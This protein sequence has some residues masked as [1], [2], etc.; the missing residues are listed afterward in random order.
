MCERA[1]TEENSAVPRSVSKLRESSSDEVNE[2]DEGP[3]VNRISSLP[4]NPN[5]IN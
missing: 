2:T 4:P 3:R 5:T 1:L